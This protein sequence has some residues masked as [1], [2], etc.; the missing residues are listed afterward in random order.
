MAKI[1]I[2]KLLP[3]CFA[4]A[5]EQD[6]RLVEKYTGVHLSEEQFNTYKDETTLRETLGSDKDI[7]SEYYGF[8]T[9][10]HMATNDV[11]VAILNCL[12]SHGITFDIDSERHQDLFD[13]IV[14]SARL[15][16]T[17]D[18]WPNI[19]NAYKKSERMN[20]AVQVVRN[21]MGLKPVEFAL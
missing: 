18:R 21:Q 10:S 4:S 12:E 16:L 9:P 17:Q 11:M 7:H 15:N 6:R 20:D 14:E 13:K 1:S 2:T 3:A 19:P 8:G 5:Y